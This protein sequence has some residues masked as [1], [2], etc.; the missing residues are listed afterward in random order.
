MKK[1]TFDEIIGI[2]GEEAY[3]LMESELTVFITYIEKFRLK[4]RFTNA[5]NEKYKNKDE[6]A[7]R[8]EVHC[9]M[10]SDMI[11]CFIDWNLSSDD[12]WSAINEHWQEYRAIHC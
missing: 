5:V 10:A 1:L 2:F 3:Y 8:T 12:N 7:F 11:S 9:A 6:E 4:T